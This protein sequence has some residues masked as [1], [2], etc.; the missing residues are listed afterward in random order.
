MLVHADSS[1]QAACPAV[2]GHRSMTEHATTA[3]SIEMVYYY[4]VT[5]SKITMVDVVDLGLCW[6]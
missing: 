5:P 2:Q 6:L 1:W 3:P 4:T